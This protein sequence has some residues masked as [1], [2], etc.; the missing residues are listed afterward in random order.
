MRKIKFRAWHD[1]DKEMVF[2]K[3][4][5]LVNDQHQMQHLAH[6]INGD[7]G[8]VLMQFTG[9]KDKNGVEIYEGDIIKTYNCKSSLEV[10]FRNACFCI[11]AVS[12]GISDL[13]ELAPVSTQAIEVVGNIYENTELLKNPD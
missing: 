2:F 7:Y 1:Q 10:T 5:K 13:Y 9:L 4:G 3:N 6:L 11:K 8:N 12:G